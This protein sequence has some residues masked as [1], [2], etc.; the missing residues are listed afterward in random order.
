MNETSKSKWL[1]VKPSEPNPILI[2]RLWGV[3]VWFNG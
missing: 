2:A 3:R 1:K